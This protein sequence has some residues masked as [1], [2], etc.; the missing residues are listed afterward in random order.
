[1]FPQSGGSGEAFVADTASVS[2]LLLQY[3]L[4]PTEAGICSLKSVTIVGIISQ[5]DS[6]YRDSRDGDMRADFAIRQSLGLT[7]SCQRLSWLTEDIGHLTYQRFCQEETK[8]VAHVL[9]LT[10]E[11]GKQQFDIG[12][13]RHDFSG[14]IKVAN[15]LR[16]QLEMV[17]LLHMPLHILTSRRSKDTSHELAI[18]CSKNRHCLV[19]HTSDDNLIE[20]HSFL[21]KNGNLHLKQLGLLF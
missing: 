5:I 2:L 8:S 6:R 15:L 19:G 1:M 16:L 9:F 4:S 12:L 11:I 18:L 10:V 21:S 3:R 17:S 14:L 20:S 13:S 7:C